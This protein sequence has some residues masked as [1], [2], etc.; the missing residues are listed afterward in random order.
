MNCHKCA[1]AVSPYWVHCHH[2]GTIQRLRPIGSGATT[3]FAG[4][5]ADGETR[6]ADEERS[7]RED[8]RVSPGEAEAMLR[9]LSDIANGWWEKC[10]EAQLGGI[11]ISP[12]EAL[13][14]T[15]AAVDE[16]KFIVQEFFNE[17]APKPDS[18]I[19]KQASGRRNTPAQ[20]PQVG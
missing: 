18:K 20:P 5:E 17:D 15:A 19:A 3:C 7:D 4:R 11:P 14:Q 2:C 8:R 13:R 9:R 1:K 10:H 6:L 12:Y 16:C